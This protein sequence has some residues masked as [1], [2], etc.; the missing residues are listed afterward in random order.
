MNWGVLTNS[1]REEIIVSLGQYPGVSR[2][3]VDGLFATEIR[4]V[5]STV[6]NIPG[7]NLHHDFSELGI[8]DCPSSPLLRQWFG[9]YCQS[10]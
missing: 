2:C 3:H 5:T 4:G 7:G 9:A 10:E 6:G 1:S 8:R